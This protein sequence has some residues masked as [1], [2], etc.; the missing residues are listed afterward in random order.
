MFLGLD[1]SGL[2]VIGFFLFF[3]GLMVILFKVVMFWLRFL[4]MFLV[5]WVVVFFLFFWVG[6][7]WWIGVVVVVVFLLLLVVGWFVLLILMVV[8]VWRL[9]R[10]ISSFKN[11][12]CNFWGLILVCWLEIICL[13]DFI[14]KWEVRFI[15]LRL[16]I[17]LKKFLNVGLLKVL[18]VGV[19]G[20][21]VFLMKC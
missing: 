4:R 5:I 19:S 21:V 6:L 18:V 14:V 3:L 11:C 2:V 15:G 20:V 12:F 13:M 10:V 8:V 17:I 1:V 16:L 7:I 9:M